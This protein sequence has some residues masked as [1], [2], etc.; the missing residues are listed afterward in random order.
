MTSIAVTIGYSLAFVGAIVGLGKEYHALSL[1]TKLR[2]AFQY[3]AGVF[4]AFRIGHL[5]A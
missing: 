4:L 1:T 2:V 3:A 5:L